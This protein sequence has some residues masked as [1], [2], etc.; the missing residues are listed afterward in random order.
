MSRQLK[1]PCAA[2]TAFGACAR[3]A[4]VLGE[5][6]EAEQYLLEQG[7]LSRAVFDLGTQA[8]SLSDL[9]EHHR[10]TA[11]RAEARELHQRSL[12]VRRELGDPLGTAD[13]L[14]RLE[15]VIAELGLADEAIELPTGS[16]VPA[17]NLGEIAR[18]ADACRALA[19]VHDRR[20]D[21][22]QAGKQLTRC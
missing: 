19:T 11:H 17:G 13:Q 6:A 20:G 10:R 1:D 21:T 14:R 9:A 18:L 4:Q 16:A 8:P 3:A 2:A 22:R 5:F 12:D 7:D 15:V